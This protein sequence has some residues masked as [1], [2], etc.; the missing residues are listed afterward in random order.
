[1]GA[2]SFPPYVLV[3]FTEESGSPFSV[4]E[5]K[6]VELDEGVKFD[7][8]D[9]SQ[10]YRSIWPMNKKNKAG[11]R[12]PC[13]VIQFSGIYKHCFYLS[14]TIQMLI[15]LSICKDSLLGLKA[16]CKNLVDGVMTIEDL[17]EE[18]LTAPVGDEENC[19]G[20]KKL[21]KTGEEIDNEVIGGNN[22]EVR[23]KRKRIPSTKLKDNFVTTTSVKKKD[24]PTKFA[25]RTAS[26]Q[27]NHSKDVGRKILNDLNRLEVGTN[28]QQIC[29]M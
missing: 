25:K 13:K 20:T 11:L 4:Y 10:V 12:Y 14:S 17:E 8:F 21:T 1:M 5:T 22:T 24:V 26:Q 3:R 7:N 28:L 9:Y 16:L 2:S 27:R 15:V 19:A 6:F 23:V 18:R 29:F